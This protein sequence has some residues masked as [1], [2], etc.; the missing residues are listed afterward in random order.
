VSKRRL[1]EDRCRKRGHSLAWVELQGEDMVVVIN[2]P[3]A[4]PT[5]R[6]FRRDKRDVT[7]ERLPA[8]GVGDWA[9]GMATCGCRDDHRINLSGLVQRAR[10]GDTAPRFVDPVRR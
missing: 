2:G 10:T 5:K 1:A 4:K 8:E 7:A 6:G 9:E 3:W